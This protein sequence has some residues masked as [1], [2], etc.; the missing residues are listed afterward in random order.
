[1]SYDEGT[2]VFAS[3]SV[4]LP[5]R[6]TSWMHRGLCAYDEFPDMWFPDHPHLNS[7]RAWAEYGQQMREAQAVCAECPVRV[8]CLKD[9]KDRD[10]KHGIWGGVDFSLISLQR[11]KEKRAA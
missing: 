7:R 5:D 2:A 3:A 6:D 8:Q 4:F 9:A 11:A 10:E 1:M